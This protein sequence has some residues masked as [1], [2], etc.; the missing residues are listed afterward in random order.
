MFAR[1]KSFINIK[2]APGILLLLA[3]VIAMVM[4]NS[5][6]SGL[7]SAIKDTPVK[8]QI[9]D[10]F[11]IDKSALLWINDGL[12][13]IFFLLIG[14]EVKRELI[15][16]HLSRLDRI[17]LP[18]FAALGG[19][20]VPAC[21][22]AYLNWGSAATIDG[23][24]IPAATDIAFALGI[25]MMFGDRIPASLKVCLVA[26]AIIDDLAA[27]IIIALFYTANISIFSL[28]L[29]IGG[30]VV[31]FLCN[32]LQ[33]KNLGIYIMLGLFIWAC[34]LK[35]GVHAT[36]AGVALGLIIPMKGKSAGAPS[37]LKKMENALHPWTAFLILPIFAFV[38]SGVSL[39]GLS[40][41]TFANPITL[42]IMCGLFFGKQIGVMAFTRGAYMLKLCRLPKDVT[43]GQYYGMALLTGVGF[44]MS[45]FIGTLAFTGMDNLSAV[46]FGVLSGSILSAISG[47]IVL[48]MT[49]GEKDSAP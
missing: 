40:F 26:I 15:E 36:L 19:I 41:S 22:Y 25:V 47:S 14:L 31:A 45:L 37:P 23:W 24:A 46:R 12:M 35:S 1:M 49:T 39:A 34:V 42:G 43:W 13:A 30:L 6:F 28:A 8:F 38:N 33:V 2:T 29:S 16:G 32:R 3:A 17:A 10:F 44:T 18:A 27:I 48:Y 21:L 20:I 4:E 7:Y 5:S 9:G 11:K